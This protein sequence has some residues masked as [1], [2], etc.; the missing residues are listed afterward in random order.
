M[1]SLGDYRNVKVLKEGPKNVPKYVN[2]ALL[3]VGF[4]SPVL[5]ESSISYSPTYS[6]NPIELSKHQPAFSRDHQEE[7]NASAVVFGQRFVNVMGPK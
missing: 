1:E 3:V 7:A 5:L 6:P 2:G 4:Q